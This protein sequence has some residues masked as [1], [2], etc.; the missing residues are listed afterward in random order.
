[1]TLPISYGKCSEKHYVVAGATI[2]Q[3]VAKRNYNAVSAKINATFFGGGPLAPKPCGYFNSIAFPKSGRY[4]TDERHGQTH[5]FVQIDKLGS[6]AGCASC[7]E[8]FPVL[9]SALAAINVLAFLFSMLAFKKALNKAVI[10]L[11]VIARNQDVPI[12]DIMS[13]TD[14]VFNAA[15]GYTLNQNRLYGSLLALIPFLK[16]ITRIAQCTLHC[17]CGVNKT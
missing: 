8:T 7:L 11:A 14:K 16:P 15:V 1:M 17:C 13:G 9:G 5:H 3:D 12:K 10:D 2:G 6:C 4:T